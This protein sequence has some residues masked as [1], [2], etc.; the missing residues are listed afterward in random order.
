[1]WIHNSDTLHNHGP[2]RTLTLQRILLK[3]KILLLGG[4]PGIADTHE[5][6][7]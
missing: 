7:E 6:P 4:Y 5:L 3:I 2:D 1:M